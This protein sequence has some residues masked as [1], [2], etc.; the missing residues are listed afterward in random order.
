[1][2]LEIIQTIENDDERETVERIFHRYYKYMLAKANGILN[3]HQDAEDAVMETFCSISENVEVFMNLDGNETVALISIYLRNIAL[4][5]Y[6]R[7]KKQLK[8]FDM[9]RDI[10]HFEG[11][12]A[13]TEESP[14]D[15]V[16][17][18][19]TIE[20]VYKAINRLEDIYRDVIILKYYYHMR[21]VDIAD[22]MRLEQNT[23][24]SQL[25]RAKKKLREF[26]GEEGYE[27]ITYRSI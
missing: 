4:N 25:F 16:I 15:L 6:K 3:H 10:E 7:K 22:A 20:I 17:N 23:V 11:Y 19:E 12:G 18:D 8:L 26:I 24:N 27:R 13:E 14:Q 1:M 9:N 5:M 2:I 21:N